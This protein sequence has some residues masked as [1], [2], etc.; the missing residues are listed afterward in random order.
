MDS[1][2]DADTTNSVSDSASDSD[3]SGDDDENVVVT[4]GGPRKPT[5]DVGN[6]AAG[7]QDLKARL[8]AFLPQMARANDA[9]RMETADKNIEDVG[10]DEPHIEMNLGLGVLEEKNGEDSSSSDGLSDS[11]ED[12]DVPMPSGQAKREGR[13]KEMDVMGKLTGQKKQRHKPGIE[14]VG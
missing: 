14:E 8:S 7:T 4:L 3:S 13:Y 12:E 5:M 11:D 10:E 6:A 9:L 1:G 2:S